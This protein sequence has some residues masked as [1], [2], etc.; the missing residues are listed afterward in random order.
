[1]GDV[2]RYGSY[3]SVCVR[4]EVGRGQ[5]ELSD[6]CAAP[7]IEVAV[8]RDGSCVVATALGIHDLLGRDATGSD[9]RRRGLGLIHTV[10]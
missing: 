9:S 6:V 2:H 3:L 1:M 8:V 4:L 10:A 7:H 5:A